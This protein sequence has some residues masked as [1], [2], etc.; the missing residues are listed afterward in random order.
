MSA[1][2]KFLWSRRNRGSRPARRNDD[3]PT[4]DG[5]RITNRLSTPVARMPRSASKPRRIC[6]SRPKNTAASASSI[7]CHPRYGTRFESFSGGHGKYS[8]PIPASR[9]PRSSRARPSALKTTGSPS[10]EVTVI[11]SPWP[12]AN[13]SQICHS[14]MRSPWAAGS[15]RAQKTRLF[16]DSASRASATHSPD[17][18]QSG[19]IRHITASQRSTARA[20]SDFQRTP[21]ANPIRGLTSRKISPFRLGSASVSHWNTACA[22]EL[23]RLEWL[24]NTRYIS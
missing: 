13:R 20:S 3:L 16:R 22:A 4:P 6:G 23:S 11:C 18:S 19:E 2:R 1:T 5:P 10:S 17:F 7:D 15:I 12:S 14:R 9:S 21:G 8:A 24:R